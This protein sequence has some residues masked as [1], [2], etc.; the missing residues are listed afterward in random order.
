M[1]IDAQGRWSAAV[2]QAVGM[3]AGCLTC[4]LSAFASDASG[5]EAF[6]LGVIV[7]TA[8]RLPEAGLSSDPVGAVVTWREMQ[9]FNRDTVGKALNLLPGVTLS[10]NSRNEQLVYVRGFDARQVP[11]F[12]DGVPVY[13]PYD[14]YVDFNRFGT[15]DVAAIQLAK[16]FSSVAYGPNTLGGAINLVSRKPLDRFEGDLVLGGG[17]DNASLAG[18]NVGTQQGSW[19]AQAGA[20]HRETDGFRLSSD[21][22]PT[23]TENGGRRNNADSRDTRWSLK[24][25]VTPRETDEYV[26]SYYLQEGEK[27][28]PPSTDPASARFWRWPSWDKESLYF[29]SRTA[30]SSAES[31][32]VRLYVD[33]FDN[34]VRSYTDGTYTTLKTSGRGSLS[35][36]VSIYDDRTKGGALELQSDRLDGHA[37]RL[38]AQQRQDQHEESD[39]TAAVGT[40]YE[41]TLRSIGIEDMMALGG[42]WQL[43]LGTARQELKPDGFYSASSAYT[44]P[45]TTRATDYQAGL[46]LDAFAT[47]QWHATI[48]RKSRLPTMKDRYSQRLGNY[49]ENPDL[50]AEQALNMEI[51]YQ[52][53]P[54]SWLSVDAAL[55]QSEVDDKIQS[56]FIAGGTSCSPVT[57]C[58]MRNVGEARYRGLELGLH[59]TAG[60]RFEAGGNFTLLDQ[61][62]TSNPD[63]R[64]TGVPDRKLFLYATAKA[65][66]WLDLQATLEHNSDRWI[67]NTVQLD[68][69]AIGSLKATIRPRAN[70]SIEA[71]I[72]N[73]TDSNYELDA[74]FPAPGRSWFANLRHDF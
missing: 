14:G 46:F 26:L 65:F 27:G 72:D 36:G 18:L 30:L 40:R 29:S 4:S 11:L 16:G 52:G 25:G 6:P 35:T 10:N 1:R 48:A 59:A 42:R 34:E 51:G 60:E 12:I 58:Q 20:S 62:N 22:R 74:G 37:L 69:F 44:L 50:G 31:L 66:T 9:Q 70:F 3:T 38:V 55:F 71:G 54:L 63:I 33:E 17:N 68:G 13:V 57:P 19:Y 28:Q 43:A 24:L 39:A 61:E 32:V 67:S 7:V 45:G 56:V 15:Y 23:A 2:V 64:L 8:T 47:G 53:A 5:P 41:D 73:F 49:V 21:F